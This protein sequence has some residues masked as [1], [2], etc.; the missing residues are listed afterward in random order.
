[1]R[2]RDGRPGLTRKGRHAAHRRE[3]GIM[4]K[5][6]RTTQRQRSERTRN[7]RLDDV[8]D[9]DRKLIEALERIERA[10]SKAL[11]AVGS[12]LAAR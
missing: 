5:A 6:A 4:A 7:V 3:L 12:I 9:I 1:M 2:D 8:M 10:R 11:V